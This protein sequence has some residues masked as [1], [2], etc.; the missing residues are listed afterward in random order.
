MKIF[1]ILLGDVWN[2]FGV[3]TIHHA[4]DNIQFVFDAKVDEIRVEN[5]VI[6]WTQLSV[7]AEEKRGRL[8]RF[9]NNF[10]LRWIFFI[11]FCNPICLLQS[12]VFEAHHSF[13]LEKNFVYIGRPRWDKF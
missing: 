1:W 8:L 10:R 6:R 7:V 3:E 12:V 11:G 4:L 13:Q 5:D 9:L 2:T